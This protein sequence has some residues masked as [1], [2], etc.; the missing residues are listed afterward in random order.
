MHFDHCIKFYM[1]RKLQNVLSILVF[2]ET[3]SHTCPR[4]LAWFLP[5]SILSESLT[6]QRR[7]RLKDHLFWSLHHNPDSPSMIAFH[8]GLNSRLSIR[9]KPFDCKVVD[10]F[11][12]VPCSLFSNYAFNY[13]SSPSSNT[14]FSVTALL[15]YFDQGLNHEFL[16][17][18][19][20]LHSKIYWF[21][22]L[23]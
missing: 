17:C 16:S 23:P 5:W 11:S 7:I 3:Q 8:A 10:F 6:Q 18:R 2:L 21:R 15:D 9:D 20:I 14:F 22:S 19:G 12:L 13:T 4:L 1:I